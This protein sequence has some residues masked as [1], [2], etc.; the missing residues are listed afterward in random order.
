MIGIPSALEGRTRTHTGAGDD[1]GIV[2]ACGIGIVRTGWRERATE[3]L[4]RGPGAAPREPL[5]D[6]GVVLPQPGVPLLV[7]QRR[8]T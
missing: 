2:R 1:C 4:P 6:L 5:R 7:D 3:G 8:S